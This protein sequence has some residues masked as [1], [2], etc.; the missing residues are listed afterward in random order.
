MLDLNKNPNLNEE[1]AINNCQLDEWERANDNINGIFHLSCNVITET[2]SY[3]SMKFMMFPYSD[4]NMSK[5]HM[6]DILM[7][8]Q[9]PSYVHRNILECTNTSQSVEINLDKISNEY[10]YL[11]IFFINEEIKNIG[12]GLFH[13]FVFD[14]HKFDTLFSYQKMVNDNMYGIH[15]ATLA[16]VNSENWKFYPIF[17][18]TR[19]NCNDLFYERFVRVSK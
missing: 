15:L 1:I 10:N 12:D 19:Y 16:R 13:C 6:E 7:A 14:E 9:I 11:D 17:Q 4:N 3:M 18:G 5:K 8:R 2:F